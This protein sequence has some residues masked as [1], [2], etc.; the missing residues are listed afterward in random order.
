ME[1]DKRVRL[2]WYFQRVNAQTWL[3]SKKETA[4]LAL[5]DPSLIRI[6]TNAIG[7]GH[8]SSSMKIQKTTFNQNVHLVLQELLEDMKM[9]AFHVK[10]EEFIK[11]QISLQSVK[12]V[13][14]MLYAQ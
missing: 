5:Q 13:L 6:L 12:N 8:K 9:S 14:L 3:I 1:I 4:L 2:C 10:E 11:T 7:V